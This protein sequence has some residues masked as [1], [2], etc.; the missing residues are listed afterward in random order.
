MQNC[1]KEGE[2]KYKL[3]VRDFDLFPGSFRLSIS[4]GAGDFQ[5]TGQEYDVLRDA[6]IF[7][8]ENLSETGNSVYNWRQDYGNLMHKRFYAEVIE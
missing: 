5:E 2:Y 3:I 7:H 8:V 1:A 4:I 6:L